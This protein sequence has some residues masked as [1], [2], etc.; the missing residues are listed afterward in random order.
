[1]A[2]FQLDSRA[3]LDGSVTNA[4]L[5][6]TT[7]TNAKINATAAIDLSKLAA[8]TASRAAVSDGSGFLV[9]SAVTATELGY[10]SGV[11]SGIQA[12]LNALS[13][14]YNRR[15]KVLNYVVDNTAAPA[16][17]VSGDRYILSHDGGAP[18]ADYDGASVGSIVEFN[19]TTWDEVVPQEGWVVYDDTS[20]Y[21]YLFVDDGTGQWEQRAVATTSLT[22]GTIRIGNG[23]NVATE[24]TLSGDVTVSNT[25]VTAIGSGVIVDADINASA[26]IALSKL[27]SG[28]SANIIVGNGSGVPTYVAMSGDI[29]IDNTGATTIGA[30]KVT[31]AMLA[32]SIEDSKLSTITTANKV[33]GSAVQLATNGGIENNTGLQVNVDAT[34]GTTKLNA[35]GEIEGL[36]PDMET[37]TLDATDITNQYIE[38]AQEAYAD[39][40]VV[41]IQGLP[42]PIIGTQLTVSVPAAVTRLTFADVLATAQ[43]AALVA[44]DVVQVYYSYL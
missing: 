6:N 27:A 32:G 5:A 41:H 20:N 24:R 14:G 31:N 9:A 8:M 40:I 22:D 19:G 33:S 26:S 12:Q 13:S 16:T 37:F 29:T 38:L 28:A 7:I 43:A 39:S 21:D 1:M 35:S 3:Y 10:V 30:T 11:T 25:G 34:N 18:H 36:K 42:T 44:G 17:E 23:S 2:S 15:K 4:K